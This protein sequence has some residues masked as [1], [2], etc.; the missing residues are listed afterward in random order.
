MMITKR[1]LNSGNLNSSLDGEQKHCSHFFHL[2][3][4][5]A[6]HHS[7]PQNTNLRARHNAGFTMAELLTVVAILAVLAAIAGIA[8]ANYLRD[9]TLTEY[10]N[11]AKSIY[12]AAQNN[13]ADLQ[14]NGEWT[15]ES[16]T[17]TSPDNKTHATPLN[18][19]ENK[20][21][22]FYAV[23]A[24][25]A[26]TNGILPPG[27]I[28]ETVR[29]NDYIIEY[30]YETATVYGVFYSKGN[31]GAVSAYYTEGQSSGSDGF[32]TLDSRRNHDP[33]IGYYGGVDAAN[34]SSIILKS[35]VVSAGRSSAF[36]VED[37]NLTG[38]KDSDGTTALAPR[39]TTTIVTLSKSTVGNTNAD[40]RVTLALSSDGVS[41][42]PTVKLISNNQIITL[43][44]SSFCSYGDPTTKTIYSIN[45]VSLQGNAQL[46]NYLST[47]QAGDE[48]SITA[49]CATGKALCRPA[50]GYGTGIWTTV[51]DAVFTSNVIADY[52]TNATIPLYYDQK[53]NA[54]KTEPFS[55][56]LENYYNADTYSNEAL[57]YKISATSGISYNTTLTAY[58]IGA[59]KVQSIQPDANGYYQ[60][61]MPSNGEINTGKF[62]YHTLSGISVDNASNFK[63][64]SLTINIYKKKSTSPATYTLAKTLTINVSV[65]NNEHQPHYYVEDHTSYADVIVT[66]GN[67]WTNDIIISTSASVVS[68]QSNELVIYRYSDGRYITA[69]PLRAGASAT[70]RFLK[71]SADQVLTTESF[72]VYNDITASQ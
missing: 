19:E 41:L 53:S 6:A 34:L 59:G 44:D 69:Y 52:E 40:S 47:F 64:G 26:R 50:Y 63:D 56:N 61:D 4:I 23:N 35:P 46:S 9:I 12:I 33:E 70:F 11:A 29:S 55:I 24:A 43:L 20:N 15:G 48:F 45:L 7:R 18:N 72:T 25:T 71:T 68:D 36:A 65:L 37:F 1:H 27:T 10:D 8:V 38:I 67:T 2:S 60:F 14:A 57:Y 5:Q 39:S 66:A 16:E 30:C 3:P 21:Y 42:Q 22:T 13:L 58:K 54:D 31:T 28:D 51:D 32:R 49:K 17:Y 62:T